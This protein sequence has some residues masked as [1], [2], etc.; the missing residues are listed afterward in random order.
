LSAVAIAL[1]SQPLGVYVSG[2]ITTL[3]MSCIP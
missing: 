1:V 2:P 3:V